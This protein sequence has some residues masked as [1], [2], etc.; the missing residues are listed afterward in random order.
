MKRL[1]LSDEILLTID[2]P[3]RYLGNEVNAVIK[4]KMS[5]EDFNVYL[6]YHLARCEREELF[7]YSSHMLYICKKN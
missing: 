7:G 6:A 1:A 4:D 2:K 3:A 5:E